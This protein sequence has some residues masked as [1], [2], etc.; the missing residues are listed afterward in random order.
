MTVTI[1]FYN[2]FLTLNEPFYNVPVTIKQPKSNGYA[3]LLGNSLSFELRFKWVSTLIFP[4][5]DYCCLLYLT[6]TASELNTKLQGLTN[7]AIRFIFGLRRDEHII[8]PY[9][10]I[11]LSGYRCP[12]DV[13]GTSMELKCTKS[14]IELLLSISKIFVRTDDSLR[15]SARVYFPH[16]FEIPTHRTQGYLPEVYLWNSLVDCQ[17]TNRKGSSRGRFAVN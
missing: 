5:F 14:S 16:T 11:I 9:R 6:S 12:T 7:C 15:R 2:G 1:R 8:T 3:D 13:V 4:L 10:H 17:T